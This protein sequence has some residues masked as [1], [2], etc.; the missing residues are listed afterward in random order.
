M[1][2]IGQPDLRGRFSRVT[3][4]VE[5]KGCIWNVAVPEAGAPR[6]QRYAP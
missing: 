1:F 5:M 4:K 3:S 2:Y 6:C